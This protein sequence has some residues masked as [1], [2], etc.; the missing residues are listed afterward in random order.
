MPHSPAD[1]SLTAAEALILLEPN[2]A[3]G[4]TALKLTLLE[5]L[6]QRLL[7][8]HRQDRAGV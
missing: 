4:K 2:K 7:T 6:A 1:A 3:Q 8:V 5:L